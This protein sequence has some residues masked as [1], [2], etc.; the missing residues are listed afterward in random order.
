[1]RVRRAV[2]AGR[3]DRALGCREARMGHESGVKGE[4]FGRRAEEGANP[5][6]LG[7]PWNRGGGREEMA[8]DLNKGGMKEKGR[9]DRD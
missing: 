2:L 9:R 7:M 8:K 1:M 5:L 6:V 3:V 4:S